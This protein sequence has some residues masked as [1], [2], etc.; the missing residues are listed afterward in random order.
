MRLMRWSENEDDGDN[1]DDDNELNLDH[2][3]ADD[4]DD[5]IKADQFECFTETLSQTDSARSFLSSIFMSCFSRR[6][7]DPLYCPYLVY[8][9]YQP[10]FHHHTI[11]M[12]PNI[13]FD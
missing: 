12:K 3:D 7:I 11:F 9:F 6:L 13:Y 4:D 1:G 2:C 5:D 8:T 10:A